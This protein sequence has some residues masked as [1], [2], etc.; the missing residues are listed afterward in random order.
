[1]YRKLHIHSLH[2]LP[3]LTPI[4]LH[5]LEM[6]VLIHDF[7]PGAGLGFQVVGEADMRW[8]NP[9]NVF[10]HEDGRLVEILPAYSYVEIDAIFNKLNGSSS[11]F[12]LDIISILEWHKFNIEYE[13]YQAFGTEEKVFIRNIEHKQEPTP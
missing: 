7:T 8:I 4:L 9:D 1:M 12:A 6:A 13:C 2:L 3:K 10:A 5:D 11:R